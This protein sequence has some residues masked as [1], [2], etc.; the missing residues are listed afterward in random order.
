MPKATDAKICSTALW[1]IRR[2][3]MAPKDWRWTLLANAHPEVLALVH[4][5][6]GELPVVSFF[7][8][9]VS[10]YL[11]TTRRVLGSYSHETIDVNVLDVVESHFGDF[12]GYKEAIDVMTLKT[13]SGAAVELEFE[14]SNASMA[15]IY[16]MRYWDQKYPFLDKLRDGLK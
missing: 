1:Y 15:P 4:L 8:S 3:A 6:P 2:H 9:E 11:L 13:S 10:W 14:T 7:R 16:F 5:D 12:K